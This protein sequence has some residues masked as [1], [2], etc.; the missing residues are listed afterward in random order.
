MVAAVTFTLTCTDEYPVA[1]AVILVLPGC[2][3]TR[4]VTMTF[5]PVLFGC[6]VTLDWEREMRLESNP[7]RVTVT[8]AG[9]AGASSVMVR[10]TGELTRFNGLGERLIELLLAVIVTVS[11]LPFA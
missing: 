7:F 1:D 3:G 5:A 6:I 2:P 9:P 4:G 10:V 11:G 8:P